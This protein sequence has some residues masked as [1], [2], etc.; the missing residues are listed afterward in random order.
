MSLLA[1][2]MI[3]ATGAAAI[4]AVLMMAG[5][6]AAE[7]GDE[8]VSA[9]RFS[10]ISEVGGAVWAFLP[11]GELVVIGPGDLIARGTWRDGPEVGDLDATLTVE[12][13]G[14]DLTILGALSPD[15]QRIALYVAASEAPSPEGW[16][17]WP[18]Q[19]RLVGDRVDLVPAA[20]PSPEPTAIDC[21]RPAW[22]PEAVVDWDRCGDAYASP[23]VEAGS[24][25]TA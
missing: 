11:G 1:R 14:Q 15:G 2:S 19:S 4:L 3:I 8:P 10:V 6:L 12:T 13:S 23:T 7:P 17:P 22:G 20:E 5:G 18:V 9:D 16:A 24:S 21:L 25:P